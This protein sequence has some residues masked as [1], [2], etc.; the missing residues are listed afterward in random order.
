MRGLRRNH[1]RTANLRERDRSQT[2]IRKLRSLKDRI[3]DAF[4]SAIDAL[5]TDSSTPPDPRTEQLRKQREEIK[6][7]KEELGEAH[8]ALQDEL[9]KL[10]SGED[11]S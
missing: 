2:M 11:P 3:T 6:A 8:D 5:A 10:S 1:R 7:V 9:D 4:S